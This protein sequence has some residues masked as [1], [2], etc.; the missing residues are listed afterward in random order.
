MHK[1]L[2]TILVTGISLFIIHNGYKYYVEHREV[3]EFSY[4][5]LLNY[6]ESAPSDSTFNNN[7]MHALR[8]EKISGQE[9]R[10]LVDYVLERDG[11]FKGSKVGADH[12]G[13]KTA[14][15]ES[16]NTQNS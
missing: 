9:F 14:L 6:V 1:G 15:I 8:D 3:E 2:K 5:A 4:K 16:L 13:S 12:T 11:A 7:L 10:A